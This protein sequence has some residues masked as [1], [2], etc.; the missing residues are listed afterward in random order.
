MTPEIRKQLH[1]IFDAPAEAIRALRA[2]Q[3]HMGAAVRAFGDALQAHDE[4]VADA[5]AANQA[6]IDLLHLLDTTP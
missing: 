1:A 5:L 6:A 4:A 2:S 3:Q